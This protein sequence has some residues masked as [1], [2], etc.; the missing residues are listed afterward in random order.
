MTVRDWLK[1]SV[2]TYTCSDGSYEIQ[3]NR[4]RLYCNDGYSISVQA[5]SFHYCKPRLNGIRDYE[6]VELGFPSTEDELINEYAEND[7]IY[8]QTIYGYVPIEIVEKLI[9]KHGGIKA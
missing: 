8:T 9:N 6:S 4:P 5:S 2:R 3:E 1:K 7:S